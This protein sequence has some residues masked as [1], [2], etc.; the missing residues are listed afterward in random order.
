MVNGS[1]NHKTLPH[2]LKSTGGDIEP[3]RQTLKF[4]LWGKRL[5]S[6]SL[7]CP[8]L[9]LTNCLDHGLLRIMC[10]CD[11]HCA[12]HNLY[13]NHQGKQSALE[14]TGLI[15]FLSN[16]PKYRY[17]GRTHNNSISRNTPS[18]V[19]RNGPSRITIH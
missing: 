1:D 14:C 16:T 13:T 7:G 2:G 10:R 3:G 19:I 8:S 4:S 11:F 12:S 15:S 9:G 5:L 17:A 18:W 6:R